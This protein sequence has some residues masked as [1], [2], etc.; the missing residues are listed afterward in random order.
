M[1]GGA[2]VWWEIE[3]P[4]PAGAQAFYGDLFG[5]TFRRAFEGSDLGRDYW[6]ITSSG[7]ETLGGLQSG[8]HRPQAGARLYVQVD[9]LEQTIEA[10]LGRGATLERGRTFLGSDDFWFA[11]L[12]DP[13]G[14]SFG[15][16]TSAPA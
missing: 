7:G 1:T 8:A 16:W 5:W 10:A 3:T 15:L 11:N 6:I 2:V 12:L 14:V 4:D 13:Q 9:D